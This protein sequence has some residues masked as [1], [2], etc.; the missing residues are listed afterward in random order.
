M[1]Q[2]DKHT[3]HC[4]LEFRLEE[5]YPRKLP[6]LKKEILQSCATRTCHTIPHLLE[7]DKLLLSEEEEKLAKKPV[8]EYSSCWLSCTFSQHPK[9]P[10]KA[11]F[12]PSK[13]IPKLS[14]EFSSLLC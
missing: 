13:A 3:L 9:D 8:L 10:E 11:T 14:G 1:S 12:F 5:C 6:I 4:V 7:D 2:Y